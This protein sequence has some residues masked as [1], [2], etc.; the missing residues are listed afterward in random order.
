MMQRRGGGTGLPMHGRVRS[1]ARDDPVTKDL[2][3][4][5]IFS[6]QNRFLLH[7][8]FTNPVLGIGH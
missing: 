1:H 8:I 4:P 7:F 5:L 3:Q 6:P 2:S